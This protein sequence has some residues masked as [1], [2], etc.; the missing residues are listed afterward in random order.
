M[1]KEEK[2][3]SKIPVERRKLKR[4]HLIYYLR[5]FDVETNNLLGHLVDMTPDGIMLIS[6]TA[7]PLGVVYHLKMSLPT[8]YAGQTYLEFD[9]KSLWSA[10]DI[11]PDFINTGFSL[12]NIDSQVASIISN[13][14]NDYG[15]KD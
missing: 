6:E 11:N 8:E 14:I 2:P 12:I 9:A 13:V 10:R 5:V 4:R 7:I 3:G 15:F 1:K